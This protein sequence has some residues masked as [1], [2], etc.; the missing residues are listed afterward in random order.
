MSA[1]F[2]SNLDIKFLSFILIDGLLPSEIH[3]KSIF[4]LFSIKELKTFSA[5]LSLL[6]PTI[7]KQKLMN[8]T[9]KNNFLLILSTSN[10]SNI[11]NLESLTK[12]SYKLR[13]FLTDIN[14]ILLPG[15]ELPQTI[16]C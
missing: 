8:I 1:L 4:S 10:Y 2:S 12:T 7:M 13:L 5:F 16:Q 14:S 3:S 6:Q 9:I 11:I 15:Q